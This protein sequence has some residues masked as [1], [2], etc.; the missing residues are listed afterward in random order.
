M[1]R[2]VC[3]FTLK[4][5]YLEM[6]KEVEKV[7]TSLAKHFSVARKELASAG[8]SKTQVR[9]MGD[10]VILKYHARFTDLEKMLFR[11]VNHDTAIH[12]KF[13]EM[14]YDE[15][16]EHF[17]SVIQAHNPTLRITRMKHRTDPEVGYSISVIYLNHDLENLITDGLATIP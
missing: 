11:F 12:E 1:L 17:Q 13:Y 9:I 15:V 14:I 5:L 8:A 6:T 7:E 2:I 4:G 10:V 16:C 3:E